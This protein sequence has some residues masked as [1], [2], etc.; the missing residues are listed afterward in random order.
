M[1]L[2][3]KINKEMVKKVEGVEKKRKKMK[4]NYC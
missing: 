3:N 2:T 4:V 1:E